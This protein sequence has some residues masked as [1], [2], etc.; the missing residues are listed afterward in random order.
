MPG[1]DSM[2]FYRGNRTGGGFDADLADVAAQFWASPLGRSHVTDP[3]NMWPLERSLRAFLT[4][5][6]GFNSTWVDEAGFWELHTKVRET[7]PETVVVPLRWETAGTDEPR[8]V[9]ADSG[10]VH[11]Y[12]A[13]G[14][15]PNG[16]AVGGQWGLTLVLLDDQAE[17]IAEHS[18]GFPTDKAAREYAGQV[19]R[20]ELPLPQGSGGER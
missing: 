13:L 12:W 10:R 4:D 8:D 7:W 2:R 20:G 3:D 17:V 9:N 1:Q 11:G 16:P 5:P 6:A 15:G 19:E 18:R 14:P